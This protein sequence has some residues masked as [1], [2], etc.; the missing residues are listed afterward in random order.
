V[1][2]N[3]FET[4]CGEAGWYADTKEVGRTTPLITLVTRVARTAL[5]SMDAKK[6]AGVKVRDALRALKSFKLTFAGVASLKIEVDAACIPWRSP[7]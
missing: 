2:L 7:H 4:M 6:R 1:L 5:L 3:E